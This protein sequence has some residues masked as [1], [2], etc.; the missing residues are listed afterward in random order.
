VPAAP[1]PHL[2]E[3][4]HEL[5]GSLG[6][7]VDRFLPVGRVVALRQHPGLDQP[8]QAVGQDVGGDA[9]LR[10]VEQLAIVA[11]V[12]EHEVADDD[13]APAIAEHFQRE[14]D[15]TARTMRALH[16]TGLH[17]PRKKLLAK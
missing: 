2:G 5:D 4:R 14:I 15:R 13:Q 16:G 9:L 7:A 8:L 17:C 12:A 6:Q 10:L 1:R 11:P 3:Q